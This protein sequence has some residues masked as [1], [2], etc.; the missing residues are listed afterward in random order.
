MPEKVT[1]AINGSKFGARKWERISTL[2]KEFPHTGK[3]PALGAVVNNRLVDLNYKIS[4]NLDIQTVDISH[5]GGMDI[6]R[7][8]ASIILYAAAA[9]IAPQVKLTV[10]QSIGDGYFF[11]VRGAKINKALIESLESSMKK[12]VK[13]NLPIEVEHTLVEDALKLLEKSGQESTRELLEQSRKADA[14]IVRLK[15]YVGYAHG[16]VAYRTGVIDKFKLYLFKHG[17]VLD[18]PNS[19]GELS[20]ISKAHLYSKLF[21]TYVETKEW[22]KLLNV[23]N[24]AQLNASCMSGDISELIEVAEALHEKKIAAIADEI[25]KNKEKRFVLVAGPSCAGKTTF[26]KRLAIQ[27][28]LN[29]LQPV[30]LSVDNY[31]R[32]RDD[33]PKHSNGAYNFETLEA[34]KINDLSRDIK[35]LIEGKTVSIPSYDFKMGRPDP[36]RA[37]EMKLEKNHILITEG[38]HGLNDALT[39]TIVPSRKFKIY[40]SPLTQLCIDDHNRIFTTDTRLIRRIVRDRLFRNTN[41]ENTIAGWESVRAGENSYIFPYQESADVVFNSALFYEYAIMKTY[42]ERFLMEIP[43][44][45]PSFIEANRLNRFFG[46]FIPILSREVPADS[47]LREFIGESVFSYK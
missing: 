18:F 29:G 17:F 41:A 27:L 4:G 33:S 5:R 43:R 39:P 13:A 16:P 30:A 37:K 26:A 8:S 14:S 12:M 9:Q 35:G 42:A 36:R 25:V 45:S 22:G 10:G 1:V 19:E 47:I 11:E 40:V 32:N 46:L 7:R 24:V 31:Y 3:F 34:L 44:N 28:K 2:L 20:K 23:Q 38:I 15:K 6:Y 21:A